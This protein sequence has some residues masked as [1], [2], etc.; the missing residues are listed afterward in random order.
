MDENQNTFSGQNWREKMRAFFSDKRNRQTLVAF[1]TIFVLA[2]FILVS[3]NPPVGFPS[4]KIVTVGDGESLEQITTGLQ[5]ARVIRFV[6]VFQSAVILLG[7]ERKVVAGDYLLEKP[8]NALTLAWR[9][10]FGRTDIALVKI[11]VPEGWDVKQISDYL[12]TRLPNFNTAEF[13]NL[14]S[15]SEGYL[16]PDTYFVTPNITPELLME[17]MQNNFEQKINSVL[18]IK[19]FNQPLSSVVIMASMLEDE[20]RTTADRQIVAGILW[21]R[22]SM[23]MPLEVDST[24]AY[25]TGKNLTELTSSDL[26][27]NSP[28]NTYLYKGLPPKPIGNPG[29]DSLTAAVTPTATNYLYYLSDKD[30]VM[31]YATTFAEHQKNVAKYLK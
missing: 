28:Y 12:P 7:G 25:A 2:I 8:Q 30:G 10:A 4:G 19:N 31:H 1:L 23:N 21:K 22:L 13:Q 16:F 27:I 9:F 18:Q 14:A 5:N 20:A 29:L 11:T 6:F 26:K 3:V 17:K 24:I 15:S